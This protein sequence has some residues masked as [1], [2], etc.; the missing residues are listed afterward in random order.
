MEKLE[1]TT[2]ITCR[3]AGRLGGLE[4]RSRYSREHF[5]IAGKKGQETL[6]RSYSHQD[7]VRW[8]RLGGRPRKIRYEGEEGTSIERGSGARLVR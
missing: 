4:T 8:G 5:V 2:E 7:R 1:R 3:E 6:K